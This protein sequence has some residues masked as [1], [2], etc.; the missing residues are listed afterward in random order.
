MDAIYFY[1]THFSIV[2][3]KPKNYTIE[4]K[5]VNLSLA[6]GS[7][8]ERFHKLEYNVIATLFFCTIIL[9]LEHQCTHAQSP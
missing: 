3:I 1:I 4:K 5:L 7:V 2:N 6:L 8:R 9:F